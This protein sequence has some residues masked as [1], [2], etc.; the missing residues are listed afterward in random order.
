MPSEYVTPSA[1]TASKSSIS[2]IAT[3]LGLSTVGLEWGAS[4]VKLGLRVLV[5][6]VP[7]DH[8]NV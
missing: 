2:S 4:R 1:N 5:K 3:A 6:H 7:R 8:V